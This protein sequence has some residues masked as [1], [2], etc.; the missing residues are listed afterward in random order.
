[1]NTYKCVRRRSRYPT[2]S[3]LKYSRSITHGRWAFDFFDAAAG[4]SLHP[5]LSPWIPQPPALLEWDRAAPAP[6]VTE[7]TGARHIVGGVSG[8]VPRISKA[9]PWDSGAASGKSSCRSQSGELSA[10]WPKGIPQYAETA[11]GMTLR[12]PMDSNRDSSPR[13]EERVQSKREQ[14]R[15][16]HCPL[17]VRVEAALTCPFWRQS[18]R[19][20]R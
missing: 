4:F 18:L 13:S 2:V 6:A 10:H 14:F 7:G 19:R 16:R 15:I 17:R 1:M 12:F 5:P 20:R 8:R 11:F 9:E 3:S